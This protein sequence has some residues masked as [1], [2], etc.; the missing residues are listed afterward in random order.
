MHSRMTKHQRSP[1][2]GGT[3]QVFLNTTLFANRTALSGQAHRSAAAS[4]SASTMPLCVLGVRCPRPVGKVMVT[5]QPD[6]MESFSFSAV[7]MVLA[8]AALMFLLFLWL[9]P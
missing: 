5:M 6:Q 9:K 2:A 4:T 3:Q 8:L 1:E 7:A